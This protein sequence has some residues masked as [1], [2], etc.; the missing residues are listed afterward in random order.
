MLMY[1][2]LWLY[3]GLLELALLSLNLHIL[4]RLMKEKSELVGFE[5]LLEQEE[6]VEQGWNARNFFVFDNMM[7][8]RQL[9]YWYLFTQVEWEKEGELQLNILLTRGKFGQG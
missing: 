4:N 5:Y 3:I 1:L 7:E 8:C 6:K 2:D 9:F